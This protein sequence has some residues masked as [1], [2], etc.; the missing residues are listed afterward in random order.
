MF[1]IHSVNSDREL[2]FRDYQEDCY[3]VDLRGADCSASVQVWDSP[4]GRHLNEFFHELA[5]TGL[6]WQGERVWES[7]EMEMKLTVTCSHLGQVT[8]RIRLCSHLGSE[9]EWQ[10]QAGITSELGQL[11]RMAKEANGFF[12][13][14]G[15]TQEG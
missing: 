12:E 8:F 6:P 15:R 2:V 5:E 11:E 13:K 3:I 10:V 7:Q 9:E 1:S 14:P 4:A